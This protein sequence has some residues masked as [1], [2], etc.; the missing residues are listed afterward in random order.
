ML[1]WCWPAVSDLQPPFAK[2]NVQIVSGSATAESV[3]KILSASALGSCESPY[4]QL[5]VTFHTTIIPDKITQRHL[6]SHLV[7]T[8]GLR[9]YQIALLV[10]GSTTYGHG[11]ANLGR[12]VDDAAEP[13]GHEDD[14]A[15]RN[16]PHG[17]NG[18]DEKENP[19]DIL[20][21]PF[22]MAL[23]RIR[24]EYEK[25]ENKADAPAGEMPRGTRSTLRLPLDPPPYATDVLPTFA[26]GAAAVTDLSLEQILESIARRDIRAV[27][28][29]GTDVR[30]RLFLAQQVRRH[31][32]NVQL[33]V[34]ESDRLYLHADY[35][36]Y[37]NGTLVAS[38]YPL[39]PRSQ[40][41]TGIGRESVH[42]ELCFPTD[43]AEGVYNAA[44][45]LLNE[46]PDHKRQ[47]LLDYS[48]PFGDLAGTPRRPPLWLTM[49]SENGV[50][51]VEAIP[52]ADDW[53]NAAPAGGPTNRSLQVA[54]K[55][56]LD[57]PRE[58]PAI[59]PPS[60]IPAVIG[61]LAALAILLIFGAVNWG[62]GYSHARLV[63]ASRFAQSIAR[64]RASC[65][66]LAVTGPSTRNRLPFALILFASL[67]SLHAFLSCPTVVFLYCASP[68]TTAGWSRPVP[69]WSW[70]ASLASLLGGA[71]LLWV[72]VFL[73]GRILGTCFSRIGSW[74]VA[75]AHFR[76]RPCRG[77]VS[78]RW[79][80]LGRVHIHRV[81]VRILAFVPSYFR[82]RLSGWHL[83]AGWTGLGIAIIGGL[84]VVERIGQPWRIDVAKRTEVAIFLERVGTLSSGATWLVPAILL[85]AIF[86]LWAACQLLRLHFLEIYPLANPFPRKNEV[87]C[88]GAVDDECVHTAGF[89]SRIGELAGRLKSSAFVPSELADWV[90]LL[91]LSL[92]AIYAFLGRWVG[93]AEGWTFD[94]PF[95][96]FAGLAF[97]LIGW[98]HVY[99]KSVCGLFERLLRRM[100]QHAMVSA[101]DRVP[102]RLS[103]KAAGQV[104]AASPH[105]GDL[106][107]PLRCLSQIVEKA[108]WT[109]AVLVDETQTARR[110]FARMLSRPR[111]QK[112]RVEREA[113]GLNCRYAAIAARRL[114]PQLHRY[115]NEKKVSDSQTETSKNNAESPP[116]TWEAQGELFL[117]MHF[118]NLIRQ[119]F[120]HIKFQ[121]TFLVLML[122][123]LLACL[124]SYP[125]QPGQTI[126]RLCYA[127]IAWCLVSNSL[128]FIRFN[129]CEVLSRLS[130]TVPNR[131]TLDRTFILPMITFVGIPLCSLLAVYFPGIGRMFFGWL[132]VFRQSLTG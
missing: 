38:T 61:S 120:T 50:W 46:M 102:E 104:L 62:R 63:K 27:G 31:L 97:V 29:L 91:L 19:R 79:M 101:Y 51:P 76:S 45:V 93:T 28:I 114:V 103:A 22:P 21:L 18:S 41:W 126:L 17:L 121:L 115:W 16:M 83:S 106:E 87:A 47:V 117:A 34:F 59:P 71:A 78:S 123:C 111:S 85:A 94:Y 20:M 10:E 75:F 99:T 8:R 108:S 118:V 65:R 3:G 30:D 42:R 69:W 96:L 1:P 64:L 77:V 2:V 55:V 125:F 48:H 132:D 6:I 119:V 15:K 80:D 49:V 39:F 81:C 84:L 98:M 60:W 24:S 95:R 112:D 74:R 40:N 113:A 127:L 35:A 110:R 43:T 14:A 82:S 73:M 66:W 70:V 129:R 54:H 88:N 52:S 7:N 86:G 5:D 23:S 26:T 58:E 56:N 109:A 67:L 68:W 12:N 124:Y 116:E 25:S 44:V 131:F 33:F 128:M 32:P 37:L 90:L 105:P 122:L 53:S 92:G 9:T 4:P 57:Q 72:V 13:G 11:V 89:S 130:G 100:S 36:S 107:Q